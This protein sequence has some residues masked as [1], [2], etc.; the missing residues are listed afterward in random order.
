MP[1]HRINNLVYLGQNKAIH[2]TCFVEVCKIRT[3]LPF[4]VS[5]FTNTSLDN[6][7]GYHFYHIYKPC[8]QEFVNLFSKDII[9]F[10]ML[11]FLHFALLSY[12]LGCLG[13]YA[14]QSCCLYQACPSDSTLTRRCAR[15]KGPLGIFSLRAPFAFQSLG[16]SW[17]WL[18]LVKPILRVCWFLLAIGS[19]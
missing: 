5:F 12:F 14:Q 9:F 17:N 13:G 7:L 15:L 4:F 3:H 18:S 10:F 6:H 2:R 11:N 19:L 8:G 16:W 1:C